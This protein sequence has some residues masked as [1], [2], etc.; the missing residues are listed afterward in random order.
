MVPRECTL[1]N[2]VI[3]RLFLS[4]DQVHIGCFVQNISTP[5]G[6][7]CYLV[8]TFMFSSRLI[9]YIYS[10]YIYNYIEYIFNRVRVNIFV[11]HLISFN[12]A[13]SSGN[14]FL[15]NTFVSNQ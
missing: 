3:P 11:D 2:L 1:L 9:L 13:L 7:S 10:T 6:W 15:S 4:R 5:I 8:P 14:V 12:L